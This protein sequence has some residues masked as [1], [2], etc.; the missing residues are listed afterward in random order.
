MKATGWMGLALTLAVGLAPGCSD[1]S[2]GSMGDGGMNDSGMAD[3]GSMGQD[4]SAGMDAGL[5]YTDG[6]LSYINDGLETPAMATL[7]TGLGPGGFA[8]LCQDFYWATTQF[9]TSEITW[10]LDDGYCAN[11]S[12]TVYL[13]FNVYDGVYDVAPGHVLLPDGPT[14]DGVEGDVVQI[15]TAT[16]GTLDMN[17]LTE[18]PEDTAVTIT[19]NEWTITFTLSGNMVTISA[20][21]PL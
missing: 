5:L 21:D 19:T 2:S 9:N 4:G 12:D 13:K 7:Q 20:F 16:D 3:G 10:S 8:D 11:D 1:D 6:G 17:R 14:H 15:L 18:I